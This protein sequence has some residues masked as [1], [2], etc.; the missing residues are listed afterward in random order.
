M[1]QRCIHKY[2]QSWLYQWCDESFSLASWCCRKLDRMKQIEMNPSKI[3]LL[4]VNQNS[5]LVPVLSI[6]YYWPWGKRPWLLVNGKAEA[7]VRRNC[8]HLWLVPQ[9]HTY[10]RCYDFTIVTLVIVTPQINFYRGLSLK[11]TQKLVK[12]KFNCLNT[13][14][15]WMIL[16]FTPYVA[17]GLDTCMTVFSHSNQVIQYIL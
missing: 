12:S 2:Y 16:T 10:L 11:N 4:F 6:C 8:A 15:Q 1:Y 7:L 3:D 5:Q 9:S 14:E 17:W 13:N